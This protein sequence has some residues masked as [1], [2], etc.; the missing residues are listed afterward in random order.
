[1]ISMV[2]EPEI[3]YHDTDIPSWVEL[4]QRQSGTTYTVIR[5]FYDGLGRLIQTQ[6]AGAVLST[7][8][9]D[10]IVDTWYDAYGRVVEQSVPYAVTTGSNYRD[11]DESKPSTQT[12]YDILGR[13]LLVTATDGNTIRYTYTETQTTVEDARQNITIRQLDVWGR[14]DLVTPAAG[15]SVDYVYNEADQLTSAAR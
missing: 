12:T 6:T 8:T 7:G 11:P 4:K 5:K 9:K 14:T 10:V 15:P 2:G 1:M 13:P 3:I